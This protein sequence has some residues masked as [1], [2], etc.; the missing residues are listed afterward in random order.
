M[1]T[2]GAGGTEIMND[3]NFFIRQACSSLSGNK[4]KTSDVSSERIII[5]HFSLASGFFF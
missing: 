3:G 4:W 1:R 2:D 5:I